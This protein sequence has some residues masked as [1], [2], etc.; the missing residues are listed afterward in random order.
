[1]RGGEER[2]LAVPARAA[3]ACLLAQVGPVGNDPARRH[4][5]D[6][7]V[8]PK[9]RRRERK[10]R[11]DSGGEPEVVGRGIGSGCGQLARDEGEGA[12]PVSVARL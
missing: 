6:V 7:G 8:I 10:V 4:R 2:V 1:M 3:E 12:R 11:I 9:E 5:R